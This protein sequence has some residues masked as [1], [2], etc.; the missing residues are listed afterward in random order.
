MGQPRRRAQLSGTLERTG[1]HVAHLWDCPDQKLSGTD[2]E[3]AR[4]HVFGPGNEHRIKLDVASADLIERVVGDNFRSAS[5]PD[6]RRGGA[7]V[8]R[9][10]GVRCRVRCKRSIG[11]ETEEDG[12]GPAIGGRCRG[13]DV[14]GCKEDN[15]DA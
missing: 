8:V 9:G 13:Q 5:D 1:Q 10:D 15:Q 7:K 14:R 2:V 6:R 12:R 4:R 3:F 11:G